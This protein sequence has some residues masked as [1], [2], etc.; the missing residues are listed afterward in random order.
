MSSICF[1]TRHFWKPSLIF[2]WTFSN[3]IIQ[4]KEKWWSQIPIVK[5]NFSSLIFSF[6]TIKHS[7]TIQYPPWGYCENGWPH[8]NL[9]LNSS[10][11]YWATSVF[12]FPVSNYIDL[13][14]LEHKQKRKT[15]AYINYVSHL[16]CLLLQFWT[17]Y[18]WWKSTTCKLTSK[19]HDWH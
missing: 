8:I 16:L 13:L 4:L 19:M 7:E 3:L 1:N 5:N 17:Q 18:K 9:S 6:L 15:Y 2:N 14:M 12:I 10:Y 11:I